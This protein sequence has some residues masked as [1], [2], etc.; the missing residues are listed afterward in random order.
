LASWGALT[1][2]EATS[3]EL[4]WEHELD[5]SFT[6]SPS[7]AGGRVY[8][9]GEDGKGWILAPD[10]HGMTVVAETDL[11]EKCFASPAFQDDHIYIRGSEHLVCIG[12]GFG[13]EVPLPFREG[14]GEG[15]ISRGLGPPPNL[16]PAGRGVL[17]QSRGRKP[18]SRGP[19]LFGKPT[20]GDPI[21]GSGTPSDDEGK[22]PGFRGANRDGICVD[23]TKLARSWP[24]E[25]PAILWSVGLADG[26]AGAAVDHGRVYVLDHDQER[27]ADTMRCF[28]MDDG[29]EIWQNS[30][31]VLVK[32]NHGITRTVPA[33]VDNRVVTMGPHCHLACWDAETGECHWLIDLVRE[34]DTTVPLWYAGQCPLVD[35]GKLIVATCG[36]ALLIAIDYKTG[37]VIWE[38]TNPHGWTMT[39]GSVVPMGAGEERSYVYGA[40]GGM[41]GI[42][43]ADGSVLWEYPD[44]QEQFANCPSPVVLP[45]GR[46][47]LSSGYR[48]DVGS[49]MLQLR[50]SGS[51]TVA[52][53]LFELSP[54]QFNSAIHTPVFLDGHIYGVHTRGRGRMVCL[55]VTGREVWNSGDDRF[56]H[57]PYLFADG[58]LLALRGDGMLTLAEAS[59]AGYRRLDQHPV[60]P[61]GKEAW[62][63]MAIAGGRLILR[64]L[65]RMVCVDLRE[66]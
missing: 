1:C 27:G 13:S 18:S 64:D 35:Q 47:F 23:R 26:Y 5:G 7:W 30:Y 10:H 63:P 53:A 24:P 11:G 19:H 4:L 17:T 48:A 39:H 60:F 46:I 66:T 56:G 21:P 32:P 37:R 28:S 36:S 62:G 20:A 44:W 6:A 45:N 8:V 25:G 57:G 9:I 55:D 2:Y 12:P 59:S 50:P 29:H 33:I 38:S 16:S 43:A 15:G 41:V 14:L 40:S 34:H 52:E 42:A 61:N 51:R 58:L 54:R 22:W 65:N 3:G 31:P 49:L